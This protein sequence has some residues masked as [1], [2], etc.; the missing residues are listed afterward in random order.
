M[1]LTA[2]HLSAEVVEA[3]RGLV[4]RAVEPNPFA[5]PE[6]VL[7]ALRHLA[8]R[9]RAGLLAVRE[10]NRLTAV[11]PVRWP[12]VVPLPGGLRMPV[13]L[14]QAWVEPFQPLGVPLLDRDDPVRAAAA[15]LRAPAA[16]P[17]PLLL[18][19][20]FPEGGPAA[21]ALDA[22]LA[23]R[24]RAAVR[25]KTYERALWE[26][27]GAA[28]PSRNRRN[29]YNRL[30]RQ[31]EAMA[32]ALGPVRVVDRADDPAAI[33]EFVVLEAAGWKGREGTAIACRDEHVAWFRETCDRLRAAGRLEVLAVEAGGRTAA[34]WVD[35]DAGEGSLHL[36][37]AYD[38]ALGEHRPG[39]QLLLH[40]V[41]EGGDSRYA[42]RDSA[43]VPDNTLF[44]QLWSGRRT[45]STVLV[46]LHGPLGSTALTG[47]R[48]LQRLRARRTG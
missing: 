33:E 42:W 9:G 27:E 47:A 11:L 14:L 29:R 32:D 35:F 1:L 17:A 2:H 21:A 22:A 15:L 40:C 10:G 26:R 44:N 38:E 18:L 3:W 20:Y 28:V 24:G 45:L 8:G 23:E 31:R 30:R 25:L 5:E 34:M 36:K 4:E 46:P 48:W 19:R 37:S 43:T 39:E 13:P 16:V 12:V 7:P 6:V 41:D